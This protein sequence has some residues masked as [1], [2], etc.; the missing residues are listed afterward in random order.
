MVSVESYSLAFLHWFCS[1]RRFWSGGGELGAADADGEAVEGAGV[2]ADVEGFVPLQDEGQGVLHLLRGD[3][4]AVDLEHAGAAAADAAHVVE[5]ERAG[6]E[7]IVLEVELEGVLA[8]GQRFRTFPAN[9]LQV[10]Q[11]P[12]EHRLALEQIEAVAGEA[13]AGGKEHAFG[14]G[15][16]HVD[17]GRDRVRRVEEQRRVALGDAGQGLV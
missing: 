13:A 5:G 7:A 9:T 4:L 8:G 16:G 12:E 1:V 10:N 6:A 2:G 14:A 3:F 17:V 15:L 11:V